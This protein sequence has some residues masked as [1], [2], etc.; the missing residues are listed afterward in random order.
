MKGLLIVSEN[1]QPCAG[2]KK[3]YAPQIESGEIQLVS[4]EKDPAMVEKLMNDHGVGLPGLIIMA[5]NGDVI[6]IS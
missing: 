5:N 6:A 2:M 4:L 1:C 3:D